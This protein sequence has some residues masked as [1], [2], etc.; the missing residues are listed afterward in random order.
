MNQQMMRRQ[1]DGLGRL[2]E[3]QGDGHFSVGLLF[4]PVKLKLDFVMADVYGRS[5][6]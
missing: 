6:R 2:S 4:C 1:L 3:G 5:G